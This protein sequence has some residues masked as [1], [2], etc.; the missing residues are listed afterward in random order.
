MNS[1]YIKDLKN[2]EYTYIRLRILTQ[3]ECDVKIKKISQILD[4]LAS[5]DFI[6]HLTFIYY[7]FNNPDNQISP[8]NIEESPD[9]PSLTIDLQNHKLRFKYWDGS[10]TY[11]VYHFDD[12]TNILI[13]GRNEFK[14]LSNRYSKITESIFSI[15]EKYIDDIVNV[16]YKYYPE[17]DD[18]NLDI[19]YT[20]TFSRKIKNENS[21]SSILKEAYDKISSCD[22][23]EEVNFAIDFD[24]DKWCTPCEEARRKREENEKKNEK[25]KK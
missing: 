19:L 23:P 7:D 9:I 22:L 6:P 21:E 4:F 24:Y 3:L 14:E 8:E 1:Y 11:W 15:Q 12:L 20:Y 2:K 16:R 18:R 17:D 5:S 13:E 25:N 10:K